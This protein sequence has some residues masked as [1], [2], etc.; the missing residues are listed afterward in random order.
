M[1]LILPLHIC[2]SIDNQK[3]IL[4]IDKPT[5]C[6]FTGQGVRMSTIMKIL[7][8]NGWQVNFYPYDKKYNNPSDRQ[9][10]AEI[11]INILDTIENEQLI[12]WIT[13]NKS[14]L[15]AVLLS[16]YYIASTYIPIIRK[17]APEAKIIFD[18]MDLAHIRLQKSLDIGIWQGSK[19]IIENIKKTELSMTEL[20]D[21]TIAVSFSE[22]K[23]LEEYCPKSKIVFLGTI[24]EIHGSRKTFNERKD[25]LFI[26][27]ANPMN[28][29]AVKWFLK[30]A[31]PLIISKIPDIKLHI[32]G[33]LN[34]IQSINQLLSEPIHKN[35]V[36][37][38]IVNNPS[39]FFDSCRISIVPLRAGAGSK[40]KIS[41]SLS[42]GLPVVTTS[43]G[44]EGMG[45]K[46]NRDVLISDS[47]QSF[48]DNVIAL[49]T[50]EKLWN[51]ISEKGLAVAKKYFSIEAAEE[52]LLNLVS[53]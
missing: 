1:F 5:P 15:K 29:D 49:Y 13:E 26:G 41:Q 10:L 2:A 48:A 37:H 40:G 8:Q 43:I 17:Y 23:L 24:N 32:I 39:S 18:T 27:N 34:K 4:I 28:I 22:K 53:K 38:G 9:H 21:I 11:G 33:E 44:A 3:S 20:S 31:W 7:C 36:M 35:V 42:F 19:N 51:I 16:Q 52:I 47:E 45:L 12:N 30:S 46:N 6:Q 50:N 14:T 25:L